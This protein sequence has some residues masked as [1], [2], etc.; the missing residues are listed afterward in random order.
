MLFNIS[1]LTRQAKGNHDLMLKMLENYY[2]KR[3]PK[4]SYDARNFSKVPLIGKSFILHPERLFN[5]KVS[6]NYKVQYLI[7]AAKRDKL[8]YDQY[9]IDYLD[10]SF[11]PDLNLSAIRDNPLLTVSNNKLH[12]NI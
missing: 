1:E 8:F 4:N 12:F 7:L 2:Y 10:L 3:L 9:G 11:Y 5:S 6:N